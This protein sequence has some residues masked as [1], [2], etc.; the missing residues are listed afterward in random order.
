MEKGILSF[1]ISGRIPSK[2][3][4]LRILKSKSGKNFIMSKKYNAWEG[5]KIA[6]LPTLRNSI[7]KCNVTITFTPKD[8]RKWDLTNKAESV[9]DLLV[10]KKIITD[11]N[12]SCVEKLTL[13][14]CH[15]GKINAG[16]LVEIEIL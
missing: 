14:M 9:M 11:D 10:Q 5:D 3:N 8:K 7:D 6:S 2:K 12:Y 13:K 1:F 15:S 16:A 4:T